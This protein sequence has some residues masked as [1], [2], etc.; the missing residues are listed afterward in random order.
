M[1]NRKFW[2]TLK[3]F[4][5]SKGF[6]HNDNIPID[7]TGNIVVRGHYTIHLSEFDFLKSISCV[8]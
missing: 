2:N 5:A 6:L 3:P 4:L 8:M 7:I 1:S